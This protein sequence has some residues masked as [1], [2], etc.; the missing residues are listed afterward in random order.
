VDKSKHGAIVACASIFILDSYDC[1]V[2]NQSVRLSERRKGTAM[3]I[4]TVKTPSAKYPGW[5]GIT[6]IETRADGSEIKR[7][8]W[9]TSDKY[10]YAIDLYLVDGVW[11]GDLMTKQKCPLGGSPSWEHCYRNPCNG[12]VAKVVKEAERRGAYWEKENKTKPWA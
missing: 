3:A 1:I 2:Y 4:K 6:E 9:M 12:P 7:Q 5:T 8:Y 10:R 11:H